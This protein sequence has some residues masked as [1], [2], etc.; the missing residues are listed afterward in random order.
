MGRKIKKGGKREKVRPKDIR[1]VKE[2]SWDADRK[3]Q[4][5]RKGGE[6]EGQDQEKKINGER[7][8]K[9]RNLQ[10]IAMRYDK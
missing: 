4:E 7:E 1:R 6:E 2:E 5:K 3:R 10:T 8:G 9:T